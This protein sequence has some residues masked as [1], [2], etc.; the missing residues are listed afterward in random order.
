MFRTGLFPFNYARLRNAKI[1]P[2]G[3]SRVLAAAFV[4]GLTMATWRLPSIADCLA[5]CA[6]EASTPLFQSPRVPEASE[7]EHPVPQKKMSRGP[8]PQPMKKARRA[9][10]KVLNKGVPAMK[11][12][13]AK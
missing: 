5:V 10:A 11:K 4:K 8:R 13:R 3:F 7:R 2:E 6:D 1:T 9:P 12:R